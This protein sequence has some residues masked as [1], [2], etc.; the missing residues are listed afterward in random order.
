MNDMDFTTE[1][2]R[3]TE[4]ANAYLASTS[5]SKAMS[6]A[7]SAFMK[8]H[9]IGE[10]AYGR[11]MDAI[12]SHVANHRLYGH[13]II[14]DLPSNL[15]DIPDFLL[16]EFS[17]LFTNY[18]LPILPGHV[19]EGTSL[20]SYCST[21]TQGP[22]WNMLNGFDILAGTLAVYQGF[23]TLRAARNGELYLD[24]ITG[25]ARTF[26]IGVCEFA[27]AL[28]TANPFVL[29]GCLLHCVA[30]LRAI[31]NDAAAVHIERQ[32]ALLCIDA[33]LSRRSLERI[34]HSLGIEAAAHRFSL[35]AWVASRTG[36]RAR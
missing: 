15:Q 31:L 5:H 22:H 17:D 25:L 16:H 6:D 33:R 18:G 1:R 10:S 9:Q 30:G 13:H 35:E 23:V 11:L 28:S 2:L 20:Y 19:V 21:I 8:K 32:A 24:D 3:W 4:L 26:G 34:R 29:I 12:G 7:I 14:F 27:L 36:F